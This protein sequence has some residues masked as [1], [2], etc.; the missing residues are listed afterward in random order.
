MRCPIAPRTLETI[1]QPSIAQNFETFEGDPLPGTISAQ[2][3]QSVAF[4]GMNVY[5]RMHAKSRHAG[6]TRTVEGFHA[7][8]ID[9]VSRATQALPGVGTECHFAGHRCSIETRQPRLL[10][11]ERVGLFRV[12]VWAEPAADEK[13][14]DGLGKSCRDLRDFLIIWSKECLKLRPSFVIRCIDPIECRHM[15]V[16]VEP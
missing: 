11:R 5:S 13:R 1:Q 8:R 4:P 9:L 14:C 16:K 15:E 6:A 10:L 3:L 7:F 2:S 12:A